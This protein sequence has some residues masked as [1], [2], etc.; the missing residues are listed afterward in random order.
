MYCVWVDVIVF[1]FFSRRRTVSIPQSIKF[2]SIEELKS[3][4]SIV[5]YIEVWRD[6][7]TAFIEDE[8]IFVASTIC[9]H[10]GGT[11]KYVP[12]T[13]KVRCDWHSWEFDLETGKCLAFPTSA[14]LRNY[15]FEVSKNNLEVFL[16]EGA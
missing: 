6:E 10:F 16:Y 7:I 15:P 3:K 2:C 5:K 4:G 1:K 11:L 12:G 14:C 8:T 13:R 9:P